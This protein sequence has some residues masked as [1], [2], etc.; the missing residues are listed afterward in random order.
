QLGHWQLEGRVVRPI[1]VLQAVELLGIVLL[2]A[3]A[4]IAV[5]GGQAIVD[6]GHSRRSRIVQVIHLDRR[7]SAG[8]R[9]Y[10]AARTVAAQV[11]EDVDLVRAYQGRE[12]LVGKR[13]DVVPMI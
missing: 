8:K 4:R 6:R 3:A 12:L 9:Q 7:R 5:L 10:P 1:R 13:R 2:R 11:D